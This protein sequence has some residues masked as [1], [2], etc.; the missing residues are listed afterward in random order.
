MSP[1]LLPP[2]L[3]HQLGLYAGWG[4]VASGILCLRSLLVGMPAIRSLVGGHN[5]FAP[6]NLAWA[7]IGGTWAGYITITAPDSTLPCA[8]SPS[9]HCV[10]FLSKH[11]TVKEVGTCFP[12]F[13]ERFLALHTSHI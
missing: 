4:V 12:G 1:L 2:P 10:T 5:S 7:S 6:L 11:T 13:S 8:N 9:V 3:S